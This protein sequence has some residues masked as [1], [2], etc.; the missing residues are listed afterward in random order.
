MRLV[1]FD[2]L[3][4]VYD[5]LP[6]PF[7][8]QDVMKLLPDDFNYHT[9]RQQLQVLVKHGALHKAKRYYHKNFRTITRWFS[10]YVKNPK[11]VKSLG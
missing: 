6:N 7:T 9:V 2:E 11:E 8:V 5:M 1:V 4:Q 10:E 3:L